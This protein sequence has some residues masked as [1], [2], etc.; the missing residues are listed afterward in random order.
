EAGERGF[1]DERLVDEERS[2]GLAETIALGHDRHDAESGEI[3]RS[4]HSG[5]HDA[6]GIGREAGFPEGEGFEILAHALGIDPENAA[7]TDDVSL[8]REILFER[9]FGNEV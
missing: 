8:V 1:D 7:A 4:G 2:L 5:P 9:I 6:L 3:V